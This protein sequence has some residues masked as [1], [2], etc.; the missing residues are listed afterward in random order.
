MKRIGEIV[1]GVAAAVGHE[2]WLARTVRPCYEAWLRLVSGRRGLA[3]SVN[4]VPCRIA[5]NQ[6][7]RMARVYEPAVA[8][9]LASRV[10]PGAVTLDIGANVG[11][12]VVQF[13]HWSR[14]DGRVFAFEPNP[15]ARQLLER[16]VAL[17]GLTQR[18]AIVPVAVG[19]R[20][21][22]APLFA[23]GEDGMSRL[24]APNPELAGARTSTTVPVATVD[25]FCADHDLV[26]DWIFLDVEGFEAAVLEGAS[27]TLGAHPE[28]QVVVEMH[29]PLW[30]ASG[31]DA[32]A[33][34]RL[35]DDLRLVPVPL[36]GQADPL[37]DHGIVHLRRR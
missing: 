34:R 16:H 8:L 13:A 10:R 22:E 36:T 5:V 2:S 12:Y 37:A 29:P 24:G 31:T 32:P 28:V 30:R 33:V 27:H 19:A 14:P 15:D 6:R 1:G 20:V 4:G 7:A 26:P 11:V 21:G 9:F 3:W 23:H 18:V 25:R 35:L 17:N